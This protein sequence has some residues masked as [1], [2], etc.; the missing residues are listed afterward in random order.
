MHRSPQQGSMPLRRPSSMTKRRKLDD[1]GTG[2]R[3]ICPAAGKRH[4]VSRDARCKTPKS[5]TSVRIRYGHP[6]GFA[7]DSGGTLL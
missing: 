7:F 5:V 2:L 3:L 4:A 1:V 6:V